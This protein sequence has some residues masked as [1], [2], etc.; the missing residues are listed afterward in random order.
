MLRLPNKNLTQEELYRIVSKPRVDYGAEAT[1]F[2]TDNTNSVYK[3]YTNCNNIVGMSENTE[4]KLE[5]LYKLSLP[6][7][8]YILSTISLDGYLIGYEM[9]YDKNDIQFPPF[10]LSI[11]QLLYFLNQTKQQLEFFTSKG[12]IFGDVSSRNILIN[13]KNN[14]AKFCDA[15]NISI[16]SLPIDIMGNQLQKYYE[17]CGLDTQTD[18]YMHSLM[19]LN[20]FDLDENYCSIE[21]FRYYFEES[22]EEILK[23]IRDKTTYDGE[24]IVKY[25]K[26]R[27]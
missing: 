27:K 2:H 13:L 14:T 21:E 4:K 8:P 24:Y 3:I 23:Q 19:T 12:I 25:V 18:A 6:Y 22:G 10:K 26:K 9:T 15:D 17:I 5:L 11:D 7:F 1:I 16:A 20:S